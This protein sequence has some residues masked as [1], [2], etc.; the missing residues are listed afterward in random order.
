MVVVIFWLLIILGAVWLPLV[1]IKNLS[2]YHALSV[3]GFRKQ[4]I[5]CFLPDTRQQMLNTP[6]FDKMYWDFQS[7][8]L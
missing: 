5:W 6:V 2:L 3:K 7:L 1:Q 8:F 4:K